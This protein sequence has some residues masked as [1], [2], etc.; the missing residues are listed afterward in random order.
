MAQSRFYSA[1]AIPTTLAASITPT[2]TTIMVAATTGFPV[3]APYI[4]ALDYGTPSEEVVLV[5]AVA[6]TSLTVTR[7]YDGTSGTSH[8]TGAPVRH[9]WTAM[10]GNDSRAHEAGT[11][12]HGLVPTSAVVGTI[13][14][15]T[16][17]NKTLSA[18]SINGANI[19]GPTSITGGGTLSGNY[20]GNPAFTAGL[21][22][23]S[24]TVMTVSSAG[25]PSTTATNFASVFAENATAVTST[26]T[27]YVDTSIPLSITATVPPSGKMQIQGQTHLYNNT[28]GATSF[29]VINVVGSV[30]GTIRASSDTNAIK[31]V[32][33][34]SGDNTIVPGF[35]SVIIT[36]ANPGETLTI[37]WQ[38]R[39]S[40]GASGGEWGERNLSA[41][42][43]LG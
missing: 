36:S 5:T 23:G 8:N 37:K 41:I 30:S 24:G 34:L 18:P 16:L 13:D 20:A 33:F 42:P 40:N 1:T 39:V 29:A 10:D 25:A 35:S 22:A 11:T 26:S 31:T 17:T 15:Q 2:T 38:H 7:A 4:L 3:N 21:T 27:T 43:L 12:V 19:N 9:T 6:G 32:A 28:S 14:V